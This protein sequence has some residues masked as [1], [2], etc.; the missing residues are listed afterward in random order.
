[1]YQVVVS[2]LDNRYGCFFS[3]EAILDY[4]DL[5]DQVKTAVPYIQNIPRERIRIAYKDVTLSSGAGQNEGVFINILPG[6]PMVL[7][8]AFR[9]AYDCGT[10]SFKRIEIKLREVDSPCVAKMKKQNT[11]TTQLRTDA[12]SWYDTK[13]QQSNKELFPDTK[14]DWKI[15]KLEDMTDNAQQLQ[16]ELV[17][18]DVQLEELKR[19]VIEPPL[20]GQYELKVIDIT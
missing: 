18:V 14:Q 11:N 20:L 19:P 1:M 7:G 15:S 6:N 10:E 17:A 13:E 12:T 16:D 4:E 5:L 8:E 9:N 2:Y 3:D